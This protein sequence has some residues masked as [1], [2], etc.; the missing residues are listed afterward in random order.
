[1]S[2]RFLPEQIKHDVERSIQEK[3]LEF[4]PEIWY[5]D[6]HLKQGN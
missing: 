2:I 4:Y 3:T 6:R 1:M 5:F